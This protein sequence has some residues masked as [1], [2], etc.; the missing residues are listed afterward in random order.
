MHG[1]TRARH[2][3]PRV[4]LGEAPAPPATAGIV[5][6]LTRRLGALL[7]DALL[8]GAMALVAGFLLLPLASPPGSA[9][10][11]LTVPSPLARGLIFCTLVGGAALYF[12]WCWS[13]GRRTLPQKTWRLRLI[14]RSGA[15]PT[16]RRALVR[17]IAAWVGPGAA[18]AGYG[19]LHAAGHGRNALAFFALNYVW[20]VVD[21]DRQFLHDRIAGT[22]VVLER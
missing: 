9:H 15:P 3:L 10:G 4:R 1:G 12:A 7:Y 17:Y 11:A 18:L 22:L 6:S 21:R 16:K 8:I 2:R 13:D 5:A 14:D 20:A 19:A